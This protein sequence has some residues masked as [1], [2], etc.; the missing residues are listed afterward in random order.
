M[1]WFLQANFSITTKYLF[2]LHCSDYPRIL[3]AGRLRSSEK[4]FQWPKH[5]FPGTWWGQFSYCE[6]VWGGQDAARD[7]HPVIIVAPSVE[8]QRINN[9]SVIKLWSQYPKLRQCWVM[10]AMKLLYGMIS[11]IL[12]LHGISADK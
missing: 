6:V 8:E 12:K 4:R 5:L 1:T 9:S 10:M 11:I 3:A 2:H 7:R